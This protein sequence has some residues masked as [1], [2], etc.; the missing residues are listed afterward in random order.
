MIASSLNLSSENFL[1]DDY[2]F[3]KTNDI[4]Q[5]KN[6]GTLSAFKE[7]TIALFLIELKIME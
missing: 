7:G 2:V 1:K 3:E 4:S 5:I 6:E